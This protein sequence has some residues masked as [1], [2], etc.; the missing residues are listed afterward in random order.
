[1]A[2]GRGLAHVCR[3]DPRVRSYALDDLEGFGEGEA[4]GA[5]LEDAAEQVGA[6]ED[7]LGFGEGVGEVGGDAVDEFGLLFGGELPLVQ[8]L[9]LLEDG[10]EQGLDV[11]ELFG[12]VSPA[13]VILLAGGR[14]GLLVRPGADRQ[15]VGGGVEG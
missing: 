4:G 6:R 10:G 9:V 14:V 13:L 15:A 5:C 3:D 12:L 1:M 7:G 11:V 8:V 2:V